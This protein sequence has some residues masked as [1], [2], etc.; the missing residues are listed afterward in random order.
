MR[1]FLL[2]INVARREVYAKRYQDVAWTNYRDYEQK[3]GFPFDVRKDFII[4]FY[5]EG[6]RL[7]VSVDGNHFQEYK[8]YLPMEDVRYVH[9]GGS[10]ETY[11]VELTGWNKIYQCMN[12]FLKSY[13][14]S[15]EFLIF[16]CT[17]HY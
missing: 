9:I 7:N 5:F 13:I 14:L 6:N 10:A 16:R 1:I 4:E 11:S 3:S 8:I 2:L 12:Y 17:K 15:F